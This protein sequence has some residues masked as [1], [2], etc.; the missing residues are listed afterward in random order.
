MPIW[1]VEC[2]NICIPLRSVSYEI[3]RIIII[4]II[5]IIITIVTDIFKVTTN[6]Q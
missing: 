6:G 3:N 1:C 2:A 5:I 4:I